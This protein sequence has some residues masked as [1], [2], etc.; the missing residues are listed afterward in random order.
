MKREFARNHTRNNGRARGHLKYPVFTSPSI[1]LR[2]TVFSF[3]VKFKCIEQAV[4]GKKGGG[5]DL[6]GEGIFR[7][8]YATARGLNAWFVL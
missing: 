5:G 8:R 4:V 1:S 6:V 7:P 2:G 3:I